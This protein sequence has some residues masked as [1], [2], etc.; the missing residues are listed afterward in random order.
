MVDYSTHHTI[1]KS[2]R[3]DNVGYIIVVCVSK[4]ED[5]QTLRW[6]WDE[7]RSEEPHDPARLLVVTTLTPFPTH[8][9]THPP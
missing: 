1:Y 6:R 8:E 3:E 2:Y 4:Q 5:D 9:A 7:M